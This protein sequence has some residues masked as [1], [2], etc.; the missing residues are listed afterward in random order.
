ML[1]EG[2]IFFYEVKSPRL[3]R[4]QFNGQILFSVTETKI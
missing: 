3:V 4:V 1:Y 2:K